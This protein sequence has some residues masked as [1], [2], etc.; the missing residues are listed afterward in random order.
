MFDKVDQSKS[1][2]ALMQEGQ[3]HEMRW[4]F[5]LLRGHSVSDTPNKM[6]LIVRDPSTFDAVQIQMHAEGRSQGEIA[7]P[8][9]D[10]MCEGS[11]KMYRV[12]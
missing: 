2:H 9:P 3:R 10:R 1:R 4:P 12:P 6:P 7:V 5:K 8:A 11:Q